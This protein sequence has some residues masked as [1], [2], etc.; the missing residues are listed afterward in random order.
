[1]NGNGAKYEIKEIEYC[2]SAS[3]QPHI[4]TVEKTVKQNGR[5]VKKEVTCHIYMNHIYENDRFIPK[6]TFSGEPWNYKQ[7]DFKTPVKSFVA[8]NGIGEFVAAEFK[9]RFQEQRARERW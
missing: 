9:R 6:T 5:K 2:P 7:N 1:M 8:N 4:I 3:G